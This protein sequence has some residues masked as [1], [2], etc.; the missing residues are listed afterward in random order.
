VDGPRFRV[1]AHTLQVI[2]PVAGAA[3]NHEHPGTGVLLLDSMIAPPA[4]V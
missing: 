2:L 1:H 3:Y 4:F